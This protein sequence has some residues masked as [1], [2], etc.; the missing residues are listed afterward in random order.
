MNCSAGLGLM[1]STTFFRAGTFGM[2]GYRCNVG[3]VTHPGSVTAYP[4]FQLI[5]IQPLREIS[6]TVTPGDRR[7]GCQ[8]DMTEIRGRN[9][10]G[11]GGRGAQANFYKHEVPMKDLGSRSGSGER[12]R[13][14]S[15]HRLV[16]SVFG[17]SVRTP[18]RKFGFQLA[19]FH[20]S[21]GGVLPSTGVIITPGKV[22]H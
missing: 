2:F 11:G 22:F 21:T 17:E 10:P 1:C 6:T 12:Q 14:R 9:Q 15:S 7:A 5:C 19:E 8:S 16:P 4:H 20:T 18:R 13:L 3:G